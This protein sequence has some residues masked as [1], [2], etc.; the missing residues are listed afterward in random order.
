MKNIQL[1]LSEKLKVKGVET[2]LTPKEKSVVSFIENYPGCKSGDIAKK[3]GIPSPTVKRILPKL[4]QLKL[5]T[6][7]GVGP[8]TN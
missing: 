3:L 7:H 1:K 6:K 2:S 5:I 4:I 8:G